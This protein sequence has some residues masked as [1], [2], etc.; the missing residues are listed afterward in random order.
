M[1]IRNLLQAAGVAASIALMFGGVS[2]AATT[3]TNLGVSATVTNNC[4]FGTISALSFGNYDPVVANASTDLAGTGT[5]DLT[6]T[7]GDSITIGLSLGANASSGTQRYMVDGSSDQLSYN[8]Y[9]DSGHTT[10]W[11]DTSN[12][13]SSTGTGGSVLYTVYGNV[14]ATQNVPAGSYTDTVSIDVTY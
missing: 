9:Q 3:S 13:E 8:L 11:D 7:S 2:L 10:A 4:S 14:P 6:C 12:L 5:F 1:R